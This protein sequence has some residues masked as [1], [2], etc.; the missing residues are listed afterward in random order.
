MKTAITREK[1]I[2]KCPY[3]LWDFYNLEIV[4]EI[5]EH[6]KLNVTALLKWDTMEELRGIIDDIQ[7]DDAIQVVIKEDEDSKIL[8][9]GIVMRAH[10]EIKNHEGLLHL[11]CCS[12]TV[13]MDLL[14]TSRSFQNLSMTYSEMFKF[15]TNH[16]T[17]HGFINANVDEKPVGRPILQYKETDWQ[18]LKR[19]AAEKGTVVVADVSSSEAKMFLGI[20]QRGKVGEL[21]NENLQVV[22]HMETLTQKDRFVY[23]LST[24][25][26]HFKLGDKIDIGGDYV[27]ITSTKFT[28]DKDDGILRNS[29]TLE[30]PPKMKW[31]GNSRINGVSIEGKVI[32]VRLDHVKIHLDIDPSQSV[33]DAF[34]YPCKAEANN[35][36]YTMPHIGERVN[37]HITDIRENGLCMTETRGLENQMGTPRSISAPTE[38]YMLTQWHKQLALHETDIEFDI[39]AINMLMTEESIYVNSNDKIGI[40]TETEINIGKTEFIYLE[41]NEKRKRIEE[42]TNIT[43]EAEELV[44]FQISNT[45]S[46][47]EFDEYNRVHTLGKV[48]QYGG[49]SVATPVVGKRQSQQR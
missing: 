1:I 41:N 12:G 42:T 19:M 14:E 27:T 47:I 45:E 22:E 28:Y 37:L 24:E 5:N 17:T 25:N 10:V 4:H 18:F 7:D 32:D 30:Q 20:P 13:K 40:E 35:V 31:Y 36:W 16:Y 11:E 46:V 34:W 3:P 29:Y 48:R 33:A 44:T 2:L 6:A 38:K 43:F 39:P 23:Q 9:T 26:E 15:V 21:I 8:F 49:H